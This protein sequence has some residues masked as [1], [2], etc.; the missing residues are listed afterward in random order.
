MVGVSGA[1]M[2]PSDIRGVVGDDLPWISRS[3]K[4]SLL[5]DGRLTIKVKGLVFPDSPSVPP[6]L[7]GI[8]DEPTFQAVVS[9]LTDNG[10]GGLATVNLTTATFPATAT[11]NANIATSVDLPDLCM[12]PIVF[13]VGGGSG[14]WFA[15]SG[16]NAA[17]Y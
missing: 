11:G 17:G 8:N 7:R 1:F 14:K 6:E 4:G 2:A 9:C 13:V 5:A 3:I 15:M 12:A 10:Q 16:V